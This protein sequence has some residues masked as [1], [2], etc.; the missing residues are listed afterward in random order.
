MALR[1]STSSAPDTLTPGLPAKT[2][3]SALKTTSSA[4]RSHA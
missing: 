1:P 4:S 3:S 2:T